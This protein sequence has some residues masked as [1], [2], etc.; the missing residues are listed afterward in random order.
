MPSSTSSVDSDTCASPT[1]IGSSRPRP[2]DY[3]VDISCQTTEMSDHA[4][5]FHGNIQGV[6]KVLEAF[7]FVMHC[8]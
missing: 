8:P 4:N 5:R 1:V 7:V 3:A 2:N 6:H